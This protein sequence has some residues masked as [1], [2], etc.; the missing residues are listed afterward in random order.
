MTASAVGPEFAA[1]AS[2]FVQGD[3]GATAERI[4]ASPGKFAFGFTGYLIA[5]LL[6]VP[7]AVL[8]YLIFRQAN[9]LHAILA[10]SFRLVYTAMVASFLFFYLTAGLLLKSTST[11]AMFDPAQIQGLSYF[12]MTMF[13]KGF[14]FALIFFGFHLLFLGLLIVRFERLPSWLGWLI[15]AGGISYVINGPLTLFAPALQ[16]VVAPVIILLGMAEI[17]LAVWFVAKRI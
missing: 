1:K 7:V 14:L 6:D 15:F 12:A 8:L 13:D 11:L 17:V 2:L 9:R 5:F 16:A 4:L 10:L 3:P